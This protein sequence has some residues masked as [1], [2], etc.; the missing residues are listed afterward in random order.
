MHPPFV[1]FMKIKKATYQAY[2]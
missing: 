2:G 1:A